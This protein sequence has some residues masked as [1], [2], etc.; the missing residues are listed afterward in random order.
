VDSV[1]LEVVDDRVSAAMS[2]LRVSHRKRGGL[3]MP[4]VVRTVILLL[5]LAIPS[6]TLRLVHLTTLGYNSDEAVYAGQA[7]SLTKDPAFLPYFPVFRAH[8]LLFQTFLSVVYHIFGFSELA[9][10]LLAAGFGLGT[11][12]AVYAL[13]RL[14]YGPRVGYVA[15]LLIGVMPYQVVVSRQVLLDGPMAFFSTV[16]IY[17][18]AR[19]ALTHRPIWLY[20]AAATLGLTVLSKETSLLLLGGVYAIFTLTPTLRTRLRELLAAT[21]VLAV[22]V[23]IY[24][25]T[26]VL[27]GASTTGGNFLVWQLLRRSNHSWTFYPSVLPSALGYPV[28][29]AAAAGLWALRRRGSWRESLLVCWVIGP[30]LFFEVWSVKGFQYLLPIA[31]PVAVL[32]ARALVALAEREEWTLRR[33]PVSGQVLSVVAIA[34]TAVFLAVTSWTSIDPSK[35]GESFLAGSGGVPGGREAGIWVARNVPADSQL[36]SLGPSMANIIEFYG[37][38]KTFGLSVSPN[39]LHRN[40]VYAAI[41]NP[42]LHIRHNDLQYLVWDSFSASRSEFFSQRLLSYAKR[43]HGHVVNTQY[44]TVKHGGQTVKQPVIVI[45]QVRP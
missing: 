26:V 35:A 36:L 40:P 11:V 32:A 1:Q 38:R 22:V 4:T 2:G 30:V 33:R 29:I 10:R 41:D 27:S 12:A 5:V 14:L 13:G 24:P 17:L 42:D 16:S 28:V 9:G 7:L 39:P 43:Y 25:L 23:V 6:L 3:G 45:Y 8:P 34:V 31:A 20:A 18:I 21:V 15:A 19:Y 37:H 44:I